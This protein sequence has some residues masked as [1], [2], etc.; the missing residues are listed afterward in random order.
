MVF[1]ASKD[2]EYWARKRIWDVNHNQNSN[3]SFGNKTFFEAR[4]NGESNGFE[5]LIAWSD[6]PPYHPFFSEGIGYNLYFAKAIGD[7]ITNGYALVEDEGIWNEELPKR[8]YTTSPFRLPD[9]TDTDIVVFQLGRKNIIEGEHIF[10]RMATLS[11]EEKKETYTIAITQS[12]T[13]VLKEDIS[14]LSTHKFDR[15]QK[16]LSIHQLE[17]G[18]Y[19]LEVKSN[20]GK[21][22][23]QDDFTVLP[24]L[25]LKQVQQQIESNP[26][27]VNE[28]TKNTLLFQL[29][30]YAQIVADLKPYESSAKALDLFHT[31]LKEFNAFMNGTDPYKGKAGPYR[32]AFVSKYDKT[33]QPYSIKLPKDYDPNTTYPLLVFLHGSGATDVGL[34]DLDRSK[35]NFIEIA[36]YGRDM[37]KAYASDRS[38][39]DIVE[40]IEDV[41]KF[42]NVDKNNIIIGGFSMGGYGSLRTFYEHPELF[43]GV[44]VQAGHPN[45]ANY[46]LGGDNPNFLKPEY[47]ERFK[48]TRVFVYHG[49]KDGSLPVSKIEAMISKMEELNIDVTYSI[50]SEKGHQYPDDATNTKY[51][52]WL[53]ETVN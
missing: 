26:Y 3:K 29:E 14:V 17:I 5:A 10:L 2:R 9:D 12:N 18:N 15:S 42:F 43:K 46:W 45:L 37:F 19:S 13:V 35:G 39:N 6:V 24:S 34:L 44:V 23:L 41:S 1:S 28:G 38:Q 50:V 27:D 4:N 48:T 33:L 8:K 31:G 51:Y 30:Q 21:V 16:E 7:T 20:D 22:V 49:K 32:R 40:A 53:N 36:P 25:D 11:K 52:S 47:L